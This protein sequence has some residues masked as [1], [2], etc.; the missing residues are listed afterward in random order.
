MR[1]PAC[2]RRV[3]WWRRHRRKCEALEAL[4][5]RIGKHATS[6]YLDQY[7][8]RC[9]AAAVVVAVARLGVAELESLARAVD[10]GPSGKGYTP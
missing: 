8:A 6:E 7:T 10:E 5:F 9:L 3:W 1:C 4:V 2:K